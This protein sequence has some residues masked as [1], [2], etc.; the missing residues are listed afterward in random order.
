M[1]AHLLRLR[2][3]LDWYAKFFKLR[4]RDA[5]TE[6][7]RGQ[8]FRLDTKP[9]LRISIDGEVLAKTPVDVKI[10]QKAVLVAVPRGI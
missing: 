7:F 9:N 4:D 5:H 2:L 6:E 10:A 1:L 8:S 3:G